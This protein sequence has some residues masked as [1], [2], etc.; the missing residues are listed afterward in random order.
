MQPKGLTPAQPTSS[1]PSETAGDAELILLVRQGNQRAF[2]L[3]HQ[4]HSSA[5]MRVARIYANS[6]H[7]AEDIT[8]EAFSRLYTTLRNDN[9]PTENF[10]A[11][12]FTVIRRVAQGVNTKVANEQLTDD[13]GPFE[14]SHL[15]HEPVGNEFGDGMVGDAYFSLPERWQTV[16]W[17]VDVE[18]IP[19]QEAAALLGLSPNATAALAYRAREGLRSAFL[20]QHAPVLAASSCEPFRAK[21]APDVRGTLSARERK[22]LQAHLDTCTD[23]TTIRSDL[24]HINVKLRTV[25][26]PLAIGGAGAAAFL[27]QTAS[28]APASAAEATA[29]PRGAQLRHLALPAAV[30]IGIVVSAFILSTPPRHDVVLD[31]AAQAEAQTSPSTAPAETAPAA[32]VAAPAPSATPTPT[33]TQTPAAQPTQTPVAQPAPVPAPVPAVPPAPSRPD[34]ALTAAPSATV[35]VTGQ[36]G[37]HQLRVTIDAQ[38]TDYALTVH[39]SPSATW[40]APSVSGSGS[41]S[42]SVS[43][44]QD[45]TCA[46]T[47]SAGSSVSV[48]IPYTATASA[49]VDGSLTS[50]GSLPYQF[51]ST[52]PQ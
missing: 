48:S 40:A 22:S 27:G 6:Y 50:S 15:S 33:E 23:C 25:V 10:R 19:T 5:A 41:V 29:S 49:R 21:L 32:P 1:K 30:T 16:L 28:P 42:C 20:Q 44:A 45:L 37:A 51:A 13:F 35:V 9:G 36:P 43:S 31:A 14:Y 38:Q 11:Y 26:L 18:G 2:A 34:P 47:A 3:L 8:A 7:S 4:R 12:L 52:L 17:Y 24:T 46:V 39:A